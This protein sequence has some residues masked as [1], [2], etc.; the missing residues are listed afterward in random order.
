MTKRTKS[1]F[2]DVDYC[3]PAE[4]MPATENADAC[5]AYIH[6]Y[7]RA[8][9]LA[10][11]VLIDAGETAREAGFRC[12]VAFTVAAW[13]AAVDGAQ[14]EGMGSEVGRLWDV[15]QLLRYAARNRG[16]VVNFV[17]SV[18][19]ANGTRK[20]VA[21]RAVCAPGDDARPVITIMLP[22]ED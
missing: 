7:S 20:K 17:V 15:L 1:V 18:L 14:F 2:D 12:S 11:G 21:L 4:L 9:A 16:D 22:N 3:I 19:Y 13:D 10:D 6:V 5:G 8:E